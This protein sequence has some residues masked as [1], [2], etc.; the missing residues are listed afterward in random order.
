MDEAAE[1]VAVNP[2]EPFKRV[3]ERRGW[4]VVQW[5]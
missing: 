4:P 5:A 1:P 3:A 2:T